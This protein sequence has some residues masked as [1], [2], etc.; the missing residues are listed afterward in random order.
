MGRVIAFFIE[1]VKIFLMMVGALIDSVLVIARL[2]V[3]P[4]TGNP[5]WY[6]RLR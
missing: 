6:W 3:L 1:L 2:K 4:P 5:V